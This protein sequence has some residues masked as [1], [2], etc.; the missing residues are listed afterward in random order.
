MEIPF[1]GFGIPTWL[2]LVVTTVVLLY[3]YSTRKFKVLK[4]LGVP[5]PKAYPLVG[6]QYKAMTAG[7]GEADLEY[8]KKYGK[9]YAGFSG[10]CPIL[11]V[12]DTDMLKQILVKDFNFFTNR[13]KVDGFIERPLNKMMTV[14]DDEEWRNLRNA[15][16]PAFSGGKLRKTTNDMND[17]AKYLVNNLRKVAEEGDTFDVKK[18]C[19]SYS[20]DIIARVAFGI[21]IDSQNNKDHPFV[22]HMTKTL[23]LNFFKNPF[24]LIA[25]FAPSLLPLAR[26]LGFSF[27]SKDAAAYFTDLVNQAIDERRHSDVE[28]HDFLQLMLEAQ[29][30]KPSK[31]GEPDENRQRKPLTDDEVLSNCVIFFFAAFGTIGDTLSMSLYALASNPEVQDKML[32]EINSVLGDSVD[33]TYDQVK[34]MGYLDMVMD[35]SLRR[36]NPAPLVDRLCSQD[37]VIN[38]IKFPKGVVVHVPIYAIH[39]DP[40]IWPEPEKFDPER[41]TPEKK[42]VMNPYHWLPFGFGPR[43]CV[44]MRMALIEMKIALVHI[45]RNFKITTSEPNQKLVRNNLSGSPLN[46]KLKVEKRF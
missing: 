5:G 11:V 32:E 4:E 42:A 20:A 38:G 36:Y 17:C 43:N 39:M 46:L 27:L 26:K 30:M 44:G 34:S 10:D 40:E 12:A 16:T 37:I 2:V 18:F 19:G 8:I 6:T 24:L 3:K 25:V 29:Q 23:D 31:D 14:V 15:T 13:R 41:F 45:V 35:E 9:V 7:V 21:D 33:I 22:R 1:L 28:R